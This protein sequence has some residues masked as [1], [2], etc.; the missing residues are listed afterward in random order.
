MPYLISDYGHKGFLG[1]DG[2]SEAMAARILK[3][4]NLIGLRSKTELGKR[5]RVLEPRFSYTSSQTK[6]SFVVYDFLN[7][8]TVYEMYRS[9]EITLK[10][11]GQISSF[12]SDL[13]LK[14][15]EFIKQNHKKLGL[16]SEN[17]SLFDLT[18]K[19]LFYD[20]KTKMYYIF[21]VMISGQLDISLIQYRRKLNKTETPAS[22]KDGWQYNLE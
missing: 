16:S 21:D 15:N 13:R 6:K 12:L 19:N 22:K 18:T 4:S 17:N 1:M 10:E 5:F 14:A 2:Y 3:R 7:F 11:H 20:P 9:G 8:K